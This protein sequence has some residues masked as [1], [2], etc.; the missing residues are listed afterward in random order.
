MITKVVQWVS[1]TSLFSLVTW[2]LSAFYRENFVACLSAVIVILAIFFIK[3][4]IETLATPNSAVRVSSQFKAVSKAPERHRNAGE[5]RVVPD[6][7]NT[8]AV[9]VKEAALSPD[10]LQLEN[11][12]WS[13][14]FKAAAMIRELRKELENKANNESEGDMA[15]SEKVIDHH[16]RPHNVSSL[17]KDDPNVGTGLFDVPEGSDLMELQFNINSKTQ[18]VEEAASTS[19]GCGSAIASPLVATKWIKG[20]TV[21][22][23]RPSRT[24][25][26]SPNSAFPRSRLLDLTRYPRNGGR[27]HLVGSPIF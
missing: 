14:F 18:V 11:E 10:S 8:G 22:K 27:L 20:Q 13:P 12:P 4:E 23:R 6:T 21:R 2:N 16:N 17:L 26:S 25:I 9:L 5:T 3:E 19:F 7:I 1:I 15:H 24:R